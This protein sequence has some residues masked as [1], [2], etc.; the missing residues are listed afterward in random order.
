MNVIAVSPILA[1]PLTRKFTK[2]SEL[3]HRLY[4]ATRKRNLKM[5]TLAAAFSARALAA[6]V[7]ADPLLLRLSL[8]ASFR[9]S[10]LAFKL[11]GS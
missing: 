11:T 8:A 3:G 10:K 1:D 7:I 9:L 6:A 5:R 2:V 4:Q